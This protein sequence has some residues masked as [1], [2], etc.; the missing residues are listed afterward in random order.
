MTVNI[1]KSKIIFLPNHNISVKNWRYGNS[2]ININLIFQHRQRDLQI[3]LCN[4][5]IKPIL[6]YSAEIWVTCNIN[7]IERVQLKFLKYISKLKRSTPSYNRVFSINCWHT[8]K[9]YFLLGTNMQKWKIIYYHVN[10]LSS[11]VY[12]NIYI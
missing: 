3:D 5:T 12:R 10:S 2:K 11:M 9:K 8:R 1:S 4:K 6:L 7:V